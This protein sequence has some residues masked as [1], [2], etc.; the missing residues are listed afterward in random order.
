MTN[1]EKT[2]ELIAELYGEFQYKEGIALEKIK[3]LWDNE[4]NNYSWDSIEKAIEDDYSY[5]KRKTQPTLAHLR[6]RLKRSGRARNCNNDIFQI[7]TIEELREGH[8]KFLTFK[9]LYGKMFI[10]NNRAFLWINFR[11][12]IFKLAK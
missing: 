7:Q 11:A 12:T 8:N 10:K 6:I 2:W 1:T 5:D 9:K 3:K 4:L